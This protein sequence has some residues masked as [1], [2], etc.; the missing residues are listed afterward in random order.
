M[1][2]KIRE[3]KIPEQLINSI[4]FNSI[5]FN[6]IRHLYTAKFQNSC[7]DHQPLALYLITTLNAYS[8]LYAFL[9]FFL[10]LFF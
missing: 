4:Q 8:N 7:F 5:Q 2:Q 10:F 3:K 9:L 1:K 6:S